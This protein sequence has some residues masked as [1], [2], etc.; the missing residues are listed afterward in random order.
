MTSCGGNRESDCPTYLCLEICLEIACTTY[1]NVPQR[2][3]SARKSTFVFQSLLLS[4][5][6][7]QEVQIRDAEP[8][9]T[10]ALGVCV[11]A[12]PVTRRLQLMLYVLY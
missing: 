3:H 10:A 9:L 5:S 8:V 2:T 11:R 6:L 4:L 12:E 1:P 7:E